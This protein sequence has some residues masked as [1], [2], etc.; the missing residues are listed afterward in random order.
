MQ[1]YTKRV[2]FYLSSNYIKS[3]L[4]ILAWLVHCKLRKGLKSV[5]EALWEVFVAKAA[6]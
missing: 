3:I 2:D 1:D 4:Y 6:N 5:I